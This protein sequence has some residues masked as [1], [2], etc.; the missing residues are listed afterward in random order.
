LALARRLHPRLDV[1][2]RLAQAFVGKLLVLNAGDFN[3][4]G[5]SMRSR[6]GPEI[7]FW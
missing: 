4:L 5:V 7:R 2:R 1:G 3:A 6:R